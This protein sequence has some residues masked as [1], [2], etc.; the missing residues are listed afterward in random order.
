[1]VI[2]SNNQDILAHHN[3][4]RHLWTICILVYIPPTLVK[5]ISSVLSQ[6]L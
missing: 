3:Q 2:Y 6:I 1:M 5:E 4:K